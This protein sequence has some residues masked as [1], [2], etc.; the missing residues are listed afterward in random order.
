MGDQ[1]S[2]MECLRADLARVTAERDEVRA[3]LLRCTAECDEVRARGRELRREVEALA[4]ERDALREALATQAAAVREEARMWN[5]RATELEGERDA[6]IQQRDH[7]MYRD[8]ELSDPNGPVPE[9]PKELELQFCRMRW[10]LHHLDRKLSAMDTLAR[11]YRLDPSATN[12]ELVVDRAAGE[13]REVK[14]LRRERESVSKALGLNV[15]PTYWLDELVP[16]ARALRAERDALCAIVDGREGTPMWRQEHPTQTEAMAHAVSGGLWLG[17]K[18]GEMP[19]VVG[20]HDDE[21]VGGLA[22]FSD[23]F[24]Y[25][26]PMDM[27]WDEVWMPDNFGGCVWCPIRSDGR[28]CAWPVVEADRG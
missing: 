15:C 26:D 8:P 2:E 9:D 11:T 22:L 28:P 19:F 21:S 17:M 12:A 10:R 18:P 13:M 6:L 23:R 5:A 20:F 7:G 24:P 27:E 16:A 3:E 14:A 1:S 4:V 25:N